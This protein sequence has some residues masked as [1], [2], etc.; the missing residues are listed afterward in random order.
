MD[1][2]LGILNRYIDDVDSDFYEIKVGM[3]EF[4]IAL[5]EGFQREILD[6]QKVNY[7]LS[8]LEELFV[9]SIKQLY[10]E[11]NSSGNSKKT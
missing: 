10:C 4:I 5:S 11:Y 7:D 3:M 2:S 1:L 8:F 6:F 9:N